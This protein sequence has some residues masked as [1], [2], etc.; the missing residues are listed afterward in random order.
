[1]TNEAISWLPNYANNALCVA[2]SGS[3]PLHYQIVSLQ[4]SVSHMI[5]SCIGSISTTKKSLREGHLGTRGYITLLIIA[6]H[7]QDKHIPGPQL[8][9]P[10]KATLGPD[11]VP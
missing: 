9:I 2:S 1:M 8:K 7:G 10:I 6:L 5:R 3:S 11:R 4:R